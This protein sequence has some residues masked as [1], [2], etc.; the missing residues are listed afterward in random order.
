MSEEPQAPPSRRKQSSLTW[1]VP[2]VLIGGLVV[3]YFV[4]PAFHSSANEAYA[5]LTSGKQERVEAWVAQFGPWGFVALLGLMLMQSLLAFIP[6]VLIMVVAVLAYGPWVG[7]LLAWTGLLLAAS[8]AHAIGRF[9]G[10]VTVERLIGSETEEK[11]DRFLERYGVWAIVA[12]RISPALSTDA[13]SYVAG[14][15]G[16][17]Y[18]RF[19]A[20]TALGTVPLT[21]LV[22]YLG[23]D[24]QRLEGG[25]IWVSVASVLLFAGYVVYDWWRTDED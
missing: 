6:S 17:G 8:M 4:W 19:L 18:G 25:L 11:I 10:P 9:L 7:G 3:L 23:A 22:G 16:M 15:V 24:V 2:F 1:A 20:A 5:A 14:L 21:V 12:A 13:V